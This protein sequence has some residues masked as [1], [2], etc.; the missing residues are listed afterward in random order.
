MPAAWERLS[1]SLLLA[2]AMTAQGVGSPADESGFGM[3]YASLSDLAH[4]KG[5]A[6]H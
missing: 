3:L 1:G 2:A 6:T 4:G 5:D